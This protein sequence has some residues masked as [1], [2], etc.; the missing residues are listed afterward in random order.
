VGDIVTK[1]GDW[2]KDH[3]DWIW[4]GVLIALAAWP[5][6]NLG[7]LRAQRG[8][9]PL[10]EASLFRAREGIVPRAASA[11]QGSAPIVDK[12]D[13]RVVVSKS[14]KSMKYHHVW[15]AGAQ[16]IKESN[17]VWFPSAADAQA[18]GYSLAG[19]CSE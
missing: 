3:R 11:G 18:A 19:N 6:Y 2:V 8:S 16:Q 7:L 12:S 17:Q 13:P 14:S 5:A 10:Q 9:Q 4:T 1:I 15:C